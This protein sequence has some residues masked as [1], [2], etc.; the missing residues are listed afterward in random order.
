MTLDEYLKPRGRTAALARKVGVHS[1]T[2]MR[3]ARGEIDPSKD[4]MGRICAASDGAISPPDFF[5][6]CEDLDRQHLDAVAAE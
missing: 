4:M 5:S 6:A 3:I 2:I 1:S